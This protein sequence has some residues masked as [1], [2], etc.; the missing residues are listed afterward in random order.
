MALQ[1][2]TEVTLLAPRT[3][4]ANA[5]DGELKIADLKLS[6]AFGADPVLKVPEW[7]VAGLAVHNS[8]GHRSLP[9]RWAT[10]PVV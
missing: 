3:T 5:V 7:V 2:R 1:A 4:K 10:Q 8:L 9:P 6:P